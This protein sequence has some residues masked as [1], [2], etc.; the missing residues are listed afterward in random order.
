LNICFCW[1]ASDGIFLL[2]DF[3]LLRRIGGSD[4]NI[5]QEDSTYLVLR[6]GC[7]CTWAATFESSIEILPVGWEF[8]RLGIRGCLLGKIERVSFED[9]AVVQKL[10]WHV[11]LAVTILQ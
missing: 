2:C 6:R 10:F 8:F 1:S 4:S 5:S 9:F 7:S 11:P 3:W